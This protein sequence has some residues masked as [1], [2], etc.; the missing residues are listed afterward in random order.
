MLF[1]L[2][3]RKY[4]R[5]TDQHKNTSN[6]RPPTGRSFRPHQCSIQPLTGS[7]LATVAAVVAVDVAAVDVAVVE[8]AVDVAV[9]SETVDVDSALHSSARTA[10]ESFSVES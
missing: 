6:Q 2:G 7:S 8:V 4:K 10:A 9:D 3:I 1:T 5:R